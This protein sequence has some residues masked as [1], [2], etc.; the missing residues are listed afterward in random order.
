MEVKA[1]KG[2]LL[3][4]PKILK[5]TTLGAILARYRDTV[6]P[7]KRSHE[8]ERLVLSAFLLHPI[9]RRRLAELRP[10][11][12]ATYRDER[13]LE[14][15]PSTGISLPQNPLAKLQI[16]GVDSAVSDDYGQAR[17]QQSSRPP[18]PAEIR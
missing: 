2:I 6:S 4:D 12:F 16:N 15:K 1:D 3:A 8:T 7:K 13:L 9:C 10:E 14:V 17:R 5:H 11:D 18:G